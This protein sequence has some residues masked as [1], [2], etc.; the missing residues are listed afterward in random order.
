LAGQFGVAPTGEKLQAI[1]MDK[2]LAALSATPRPF[3]PVLDGR[4]FTHNPFDPAAPA[5]SSD[6]PFMAGNA[7]TEATLYMAVDRNNFILDGAEVTRRVGRFLRTDAAETN[8]VMDAY[9][10]ANPG[11]S[12]SEVLAAIA[13]DYTYRRNTTRE[14]ALQCATAQAPV[15]AY[16][17]DWKT[18]VW[19]GV[20]HTPHT[21]E[22]PFVFGTAPAAAGL[23]GTGADIEP[24]TKMMIAT[25][26]AFAHTGNPNNPALPLWPKYDARTRS[27]MMLDLNSHVASDPGGVARASLDPLPPFEYSIPVNYPR[28]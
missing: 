6:I 2:L 16:V 10:T 20:L 7:A 9:Q 22:V 15:Y 8:R 12:P 18:P 24:L 28:A 13:T 14:A 1:P 5:T 19:D 23:V 27:T 17:F 21:S 11:F 26:S 4:S 3:R 25:W